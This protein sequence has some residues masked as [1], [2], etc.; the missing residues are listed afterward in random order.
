MTVRRLVGRV[1]P[2]VAIVAALALFALWRF[3]SPD[4]L[5]LPNTARPLTGLVS[6][7]GSHPTKKQGG[8]YY[9]D[10][11]ERQASWLERL[12]PFTRPDG[13]S[14]VPNRAVVPKGVSF[15]DE[16]KQE[17]ED[18]T[19]S[20]Q[21][22]AAVALRYAGLRVVARP[23]GVLVEGVYSNVPAAKVIR[24][25]DVIV[26]VNG[27]AVLSRL[28]LRAALAKRA[29]GDVVSLRVLRGGKALIV[30]TKTI[31]D[32]RE[33]KRPLIGIYRASQAA[34]ITL[35]LKVHIDLRGVGGP[36]AG[37]PFALDVLELL[38]TDVT[39][40]NRVAATG[41]LDLDGS[42]S[43]IGGVKQKTYGARRAGV[44]VLLVPAGENA[45]EA[46]RY[47]GGLRVIPVESFQQAL[48]AL[49]TLPPKR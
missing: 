24:S 15:E 9:L 5:F 23:T 10:V 22:A 36:S 38:G 28:E 32:P 44:D 17:L 47:A 40:G 41:E 16:H 4:Y 26:G 30:S 34:T 12:L 6:V 18:M 8:I 37:L 3:P 20:Q 21:V 14:L 11:T 7:E 43:P 27:R 19:R 25:G 39:H 35:P 2:I 46:R 13:A 49:A 1:L 31:S 33:P 48:H 29:P 45:V 42:V